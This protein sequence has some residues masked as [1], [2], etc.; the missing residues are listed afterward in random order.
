MQQNK[1]IK[2]GFILAGLVN[3]IGILAITQGLTSDTL[4]QADPAVF[5]TFGILMIMV[6]GL[7][8]LATVRFATTAV[9]LPAVFA[10]EKLAYTLN[11]VFWMDD[12]ADSVST[13]T[14]QDF[15]GGFF[16]GGYGI[17][18]GLFCLFFAVVAFLN[19][20]SKAVN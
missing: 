17:N 18:D 19:W 9:L 2:G 13:I 14:E 4:A 20:R 16:M 10:I 5:S 7:A 15:L 3:I 8:Y 12:N 6:W 11:W 1:I